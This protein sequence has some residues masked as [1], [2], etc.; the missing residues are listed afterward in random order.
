QEFGGAGVGGRSD[1]VVHPLALAARLDDP[2]AAQVGQMAADLG[3]RLLQDFD[4]IADAE[5]LVAHQ[6][7][8]AQAGDVSQ[9]LEEAFHVEVNW[10]GARLHCHGSL[11]RLDEY[12]GKRYIRFSIYIFAAEPELPVS[13]RLRCRTI[14]SCFYA[15]ATPHGRFWRR[16]S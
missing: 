6:V 16:Q 3:L 11:I 8:Q 12:V 5:L 4:E 10:L 2:R 9:R 7:E 14:T 13:R 1:A 15:R